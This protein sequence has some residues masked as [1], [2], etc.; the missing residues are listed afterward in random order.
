MTTEMIPYLAIGFF[1]VFVA[2]I[3]QAML[4]KASGQ[5]QKDLLHEYLNPLT[6]TA[7]AMFFCSTLMTMVSLRKVPLA[8]S[9]MY[10]SSSYIFVTI[11][12]AL[13]FS[14]KI[15]VNKLIGL[16]FILSGIVLL[17]I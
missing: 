8:M 4:K 6:V 7:Y 15:T 2:S 1:S 14:E 12:G 16:G 5:K 17:A 11:F 13:F 10:E 3:S 9:P